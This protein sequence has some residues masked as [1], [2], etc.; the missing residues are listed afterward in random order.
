VASVDRGIV[1]RPAGR[2]RVVVERGPVA[3]FA[4]AVRDEDPAYRDPAAAEAAGLPA[5][6]APPTFPFAM[7]HWGRFV[8]VQPAP[9]PEGHAGQVDAIGEVLGPLLGKGGII[10]HGEQ[11]FEYERPVLVGDVLDGQT[12]VVDVYEKES[13]GRVMTFLVLETVWS[14]ASSGARVVASRMN[15]I[16]RS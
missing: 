3:N 7:E 15:L 10:L 9:D 12:T 6:P 2:A 14:D 5:I 11:S 13:K 1:G 4:R 16:H 8:E